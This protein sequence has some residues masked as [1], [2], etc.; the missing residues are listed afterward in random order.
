MCAHTLTMKT[1]GLTGGIGMGKSTAADFLL[2]RGISV[3]DS[4]A[5]ARQIVEPGQP[6]LG[7]IKQVFGDDII[8]SEGRL[9]RDRLA[10][11]VFSDADA[12]RKLEAILHPRIRAIWQ[13]QLET[14]SAEGRPSAVAMIPLLFE[15]GAAGEFSATI[16][17]A[18]SQVTQR[19]RL[20]ARGWTDD[21]INLRIGAQMPIEKKMALADYVVWTEG[22]I[23]VHQAQ[24]QRITT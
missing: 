8:D 18:C 14:W 9:Q 6:A 24:L 10:A 2:Q 1:F 19:L 20:R 21:Q 13:A 16:C 23:D 11:R 22:E 12:R 5:I 4:D 7:E 17:I 3:V 15:T